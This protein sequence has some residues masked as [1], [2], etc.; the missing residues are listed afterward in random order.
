[1]FAFKLS[2]FIFIV[3]GKLINGKELQQQQQHHFTH[4]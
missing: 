2:Y 3:K 1:M 4:R